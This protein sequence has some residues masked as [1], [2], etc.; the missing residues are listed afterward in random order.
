ML[1]QY[2]EEIDVYFI[3]ELEGDYTVYRLDVEDNDLYFAN[4][5]LT[6]NAIKLGFD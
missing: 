5:L 4:G 3:E 1:N 2:E 6:H